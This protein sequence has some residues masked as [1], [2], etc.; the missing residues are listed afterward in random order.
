MGAIA[1]HSTG[2]LF[3]S[4]EYAVQRFSPKL[5]LVL[6]VSDSNV[7]ASSLDHL[8]GQATSFGPTHIVHE[9]I[10]ASALNALKQTGVGGNTHKVLTKAGRDMKQR[11][12]TVE[13]NALYTVERLLRCSEVIRDAVMRGKMEVQVG[14]LQEDTGKVEFIGAHPMQEE[15]LKREDAQRAQVVQDKS[16]PAVRDSG[17]YYR[18]NHMGL[19]NSKDAKLQRKARFES[20]ATPVRSDDMGIQRDSGAYFRTR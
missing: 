2:S 3:K 18:T 6:G 13:L 14:I 15:F 5:L 20:K 4:L 19:V 16:K 7:I 17:A 9:A 8:D 10:G 12:L 1:G 11:G